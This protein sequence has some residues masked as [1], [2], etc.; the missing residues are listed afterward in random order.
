MFGFLMIVVFLSL[1]KFVLAE[2][3]SFIKFYDI[4]IILQRDGIKIKKGQ[5]ECH[6]KNDNSQVVYCMVG[7]LIIWPSGESKN[8]I[9]LRKG[10]LNRYCK[11]VRQYLKQDMDYTQ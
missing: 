4:K 10:F 5:Y 8:M 7:W 6:I 11:K 9:L 3:M 2:F 1:A